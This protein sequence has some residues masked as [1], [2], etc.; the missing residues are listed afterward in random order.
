[1]KG[2]LEKEGKYELFETTHGHQILNLNN[3]SFFAIVEG[4]K[5]DI[6]VKSDSDHK[7]KKT[8]S[9]GKFYLADFNNDPEFRDIPH[10]FLE[11]GKKYRE[12]IL[13]NDEPSKRDYQK[14]LVRTDNLVDKGKVEN[15]VKDKDKKVAEKNS[16]RTDKEAKSSKDLQK[17][18]E[19]VQRM[20]G[21]KKKSDF[22]NK[23]KTELYELAKKKKIEG[24]SNMNKD[25]LIKALK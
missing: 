5:G 15:H 4:Q 13:P 3:E 21:A 23:T 11:E 12:W 25:D 10:L 16:N 24:R 22:E 6:I 17:S 1:M 7:K 20:R 8:L 2:K 19:N 18:S 14:K 9:K